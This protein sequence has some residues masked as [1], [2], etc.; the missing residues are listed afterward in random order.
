MPKHAAIGAVSLCLLSAGGSQAVLGQPSDPRIRH[1]A[2]DNGPPAPMPGLGQDEM[3]YFSDGLARFS[4]VEVVSGAVA[5]QGN[6]LGPRFNSDSCL[7]C[8]AQPNAGGSSPAANPLMNIAAAYGAS[9]SIPWF[10]TAN[11]PIRGRAL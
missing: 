7:S 1:A 9:N 3:E 2:T 8:H 10:L 11:G 5:G 6:G 4:I